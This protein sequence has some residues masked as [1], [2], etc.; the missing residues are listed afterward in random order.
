[1]RTYNLNDVFRSEGI[2]FGLFVSSVLYSSI[3]IYRSYNDGTSWTD[4]NIFAFIP[5]FFAAWVTLTGLA[6]QARISQQIEDERY[7]SEERAALSN[8]P[9]ATSA[10][11][12]LCNEML[13]HFVDPKNPAPDLTK[14]EKNLQLYRDSIR[15]SNERTGLRLLGIIRMYQVLAARFYAAQPNKNGKVLSVDYGYWA[16]ACNWACLAAR[17]EQV[18]EYARGTNPDVSDEPVNERVESQFFLIVHD[19]TLY[20]CL[21]Q[22]LNRRAA[23]NSFEAGF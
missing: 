10:L 6:K 15:F 4:S 19:W 12:R 16:E 22:V 7:K 1:M 3:E 20:P 2:A 11:M 21:R 8:L 17:I 5:V 13:S 23:Q 14:F 18:F 9:I